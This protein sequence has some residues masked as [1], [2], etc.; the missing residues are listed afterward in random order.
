MVYPQYYTPCAIALC[1]TW[2]YMPCAIDF[3]WGFWY[4][5]LPHSFTLRAQLLAASTSAVEWYKSRAHISS[6]LSKVQILYEPTHR[7]HI[8]SFLSKVQILYEP[9]H[10]E[11]SIIRMSILLPTHQYAI[12]M[13]IRI[14]NVCHIYTCIYVWRMY[15][16]YM[17]IRM[18][19]V[20]HIHVYTY[21]WRMY[22]IYM[23][24]YTYEECMPY[25]VH[26]R[27]KV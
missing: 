25:T 22:A 21:V 18:K 9:T 4:S 10:S 11:Q 27:C 20:C 14:K 13:Y 1:Y 2:A 15:A 5:T 12:Y 7:A 24:V 17:Y 16:I 8:S 23:Y 26:I 3:S 19:N 6:F